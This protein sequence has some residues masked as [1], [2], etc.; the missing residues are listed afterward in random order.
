MSE[1]LGRDVTGYLLLLPSEAPR[2]VQRDHE[3]D[4]GTQRPALPADYDRLSSVINQP[5]KMRIGD[6]SRNGNATV[7]ATKSF[8]AETLRA[9]FEVLPGRRNR[10]LSL[11]SLVVKIGQ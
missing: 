4:G 7:V 9:V 3:H 5:D 11:I 6:L 10:A 8:G 2:H 1:L